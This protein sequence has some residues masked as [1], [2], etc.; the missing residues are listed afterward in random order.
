MNDLHPVRLFFVRGATQNAHEV[1]QKSEVSPKLYG[2]SALRL[3]CAVESVGP[4]ER[5]IK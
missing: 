5:I 3:V 4:V 2:Y 1:C